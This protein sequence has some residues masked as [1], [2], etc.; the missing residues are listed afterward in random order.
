MLYLLSQGICD[1]AGCVILASEA[2]VKKNNLTPPPSLMSL[3]MASQDVF[4]W[5][6][7]EFFEYY[8]NFVGYL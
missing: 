5:P 3:V 7:A 4:H 8:L 2:A 6:S 1:G